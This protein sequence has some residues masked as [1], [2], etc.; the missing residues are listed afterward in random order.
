MSAFAVNLKKFRKQ[1][2]YSQQEL[3]KV[4]HYGYTAIA[5]YES[6]RNEPSIDDLIRLS[7]VLDVTLE[8]LV[9]ME[10]STEEIELVSAFRKLNAENKNR[11][12]D[13]SNALQI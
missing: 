1:K 5:N 6:G 2:G 12:L 8:E 9:G 7:Q 4:L 3:A 11:I 13:L 10:L